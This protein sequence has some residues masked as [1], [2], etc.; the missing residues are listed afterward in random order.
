VSSYV[1]SIR[2]RE[3]ASVSKKD[4]PKKPKKYAKHTLHTTIMGKKALVNGLADPI[5]KVKAVIDIYV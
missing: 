3:I 4:M 1:S 5:P 2:P